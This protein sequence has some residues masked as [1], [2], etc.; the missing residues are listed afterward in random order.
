M[1]F[2]TINAAKIIDDVVRSFEIQANEK[3]IELKKEIKAKEPINVYADSDKVTWVLVNL[4]SNAMRYTQQGGKITVSIDK[5]GNKAY[6]SV[7]D[8]GIGIPKKYQ[9]KI[10]EKFTQVKNDGVTAGGAGLGLAI[11]KDIVKAHK[12]RIWVE[13]EEGKGSTFM[14]T[15]PLME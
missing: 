15:L 6:I 7:K 12:G 8:T 13:S 11:S 1:E 10:F 14:F 9:E 4:I 2:R 3:G 5:N